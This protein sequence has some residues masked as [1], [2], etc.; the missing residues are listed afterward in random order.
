M[1]NWECSSGYG[2]QNFPEGSN[3]LFT[4]LKIILDRGY[5]AMF[6]DF[7]LKAL[8]NTWDEGKIGPNA[9]QKVG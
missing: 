5:M 6:S 8:I 3:H 4:F 9:F 7:S 1:F 2:G